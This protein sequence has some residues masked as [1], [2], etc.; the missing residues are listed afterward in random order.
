MALWCKQR[1]RDASN[2]SDCTASNVFHAIIWHQNPRVIA[3]C[4]AV[5]MNDALF[6]SPILNG[7]IGVCLLGQG[8]S[9]VSHSCA[10]FNLF[11]VALDRG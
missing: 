5:R 1:K 9:L 6:V 10:V 8:P 3:I 2:K 4:L 11:H 7:S